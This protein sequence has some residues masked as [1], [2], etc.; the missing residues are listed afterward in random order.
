MKYTI[1]I[2]EL[3]ETWEIDV[4]EVMN[5]WGVTDYG[6]TISIHTDM[7]S[8]QQSAIDCD[9]RN[10]TYNLAAAPGLYKL[11]EKYGRRIDALED[12]P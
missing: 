9:D 11:I 6:K 5:L 8:A 1:Y 3:N 7:V 10:A 12:H 2:K 4:W